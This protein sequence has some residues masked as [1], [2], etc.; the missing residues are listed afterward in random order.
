MI[1]NEELL[2]RIRVIYKNSRKTY[3]YPRVHQALKMEAFAEDVIELL[4]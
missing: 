2:K 1:D 3:G 4:V